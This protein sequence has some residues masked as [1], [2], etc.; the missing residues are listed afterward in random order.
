M[1]ERI[2][3]KTFTGELQKRYIQWL[4]SQWEYSNLAYLALQLRNIAQK[5]IQSLY[6]KGR[7]RLCPDREKT[8]TE[9]RGGPAQCPG[10]IL[11]TQTRIKNPY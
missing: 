6:T 11:V 3:Q 5:Q 9:Q 8:T 1:D 4:L 10:R 2:Q 7:S